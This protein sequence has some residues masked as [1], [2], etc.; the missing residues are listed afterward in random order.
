[1]RNEQEIKNTLL[2]KASEDAEFRT[3]LLENPHAAVEA[4]VGL[5]I[6]ASISISVHEESPTSLHFVIPAAGKL[7]KS[8]M[9]A[10]AGGWDGW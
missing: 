7:S 10:I 4:G 8:E 5:R 3:K 6:P 9:Q 1:M 2:A